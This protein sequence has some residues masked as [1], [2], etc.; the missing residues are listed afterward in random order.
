MHKDKTPHK[1]ANWMSQDPVFREVQ[2][3]AIRLINRINDLPDANDGSEIDKKLAVLA[4]QGA[5]EYAHRAHI[6]E[7]EA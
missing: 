5:V 6:E 2:H 4:V 3:Y 7:T 1:V